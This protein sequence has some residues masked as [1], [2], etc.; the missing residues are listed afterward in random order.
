LSL[1]IRRPRIAALDFSFPA[2]SS[3]QTDITA[4]IGDEAFPICLAYGVASR[5]PRST[6][7]ANLTHSSA[8]GRAATNGF[9]RG[10]A[11]P[12]QSK[13]SQGRHANPKSVVDHSAHCEW[14]GWMST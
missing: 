9:V 14:R 8:M 2:H 6:V 3:H 7:E 13:E 1:A 10:A 4:F 11:G 5:L 12:Q